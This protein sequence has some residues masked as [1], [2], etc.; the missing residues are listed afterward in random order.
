M[1]HFLFQTITLLSDNKS[2][3][4][5]TDTMRNLWILQYFNKLEIHTL[6]L[7][8]KIDKGEF[9]R[10]S[11]IYTTRKMRKQFQTTTQLLEYLFSKSYE[12]S[13][14]EIDFK[15]GWRIKQRPFISLIFYSNSTKER[16]TLINQLLK[17]GGQS[18]FDIS[19]LKENYPYFFNSFNEVVQI[20]ADELPLP[21]EFW[22][23]EKKKAWNKMYDL[24]NS[25]K[26]NQKT[27]DNETLFYSD[28]IDKV[29]DESNN[30]FSTNQPT[31]VNPFE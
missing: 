19:V 4:L 18:I 13:H 2:F 14:L 26:A 7:H 27:C 31:D 5:S 12:I 3:E 20:G 29:N 10:K 24:V 17:I 25:P 22:S 15:N 21:D 1:Q 8:Y 6:N 16:N 11:T 28:N 30:W 9:Q 23:A